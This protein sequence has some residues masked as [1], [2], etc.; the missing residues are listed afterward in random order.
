MLRNKQRFV[1]G[2]SH[3]GKN[4]MFV[5]QLQSK[6]APGFGAKKS[7]FFI[8]DMIVCMGSNIVNSKD[9]NPVQTN[10]FQ[11]HLKSKSVPIIVDGKKINAFPEEKKLS[12][13]QA[14]WLIDPQGSG[15]YI[16]AGAKVEYSRKHQR[17][18]HEQDKKATQ[19][20]FTAAWINHGVNPQNA[21]YLYYVFPV[22]SIE[23]MQKFAKSNKSVKIIRQ[24]ANAHAISIPSKKLWAAVLFRSQR[25]NFIPLVAKVDRACL[26]M[27]KKTATGYK[28]TVT[29]PDLNFKKQGKFKIIS[30]RPVMKLILKG[31]WKLTS[32]N[33]DIKI[34]QRT[35]KRTILEINCH[36]GLSND[37]VLNQAG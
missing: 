17:S 1:G 2:L 18:R 3:F 24:N 14:H 15:Y 4:G 21:S 32:K 36:D 13:S 23:K 7:F 20:D 29:D 11:R 9:K 8:D 26:L 10:L 19:G 31:S 28:L 25:T 30:K 33:K 6:H 12:S 37:I 27:L 5:T 16:P 34:K 35:A 22:S